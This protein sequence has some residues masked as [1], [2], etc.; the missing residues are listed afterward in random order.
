M[1]SI[2]SFM[3]TSA[4]GVRTNA[5]HISESSSIPSLESLIDEA[6]EWYEKLADFADN[7][8]GNAAVIKQ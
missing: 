7:F 2:V 5:I 3:D 4:D 8:I 6:N 1:N